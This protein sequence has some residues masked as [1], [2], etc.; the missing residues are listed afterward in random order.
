M[1]G[2]DCAR[3][4]EQGCCPDKRCLF[5]K[6]CSRLTINHGQQISLLKALR[7][8][9]GVKKVVIASGIRHDL[10]LADKK[11]GTKYLQQVIRHHV[12]GQMKIAPEHSEMHVLQK[13]GKAGREALL[14]FRDLFFDLTKRGGKKLFLTYYLI[15][16]HPGCNDDDMAQLRSFAIRDLHLLP[17]Q[18]QVF[19]PTPS[20]WSTLMYWT[21]R[22]PFSGKP[23]FVEKTSR[24]RE[25]QKDIL[26]DRRTK[27]RQTDRSRTKKRNTRR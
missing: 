10:I 14:T 3:K 13:M 22:D 24:G 2:I 5:P 20:T 23:C 21:E 1:Y 25:R 12:S 19:T 27:K 9:N 17:E 6:I 26:A 4:A 7:A 16:A 18:V 15:A 11:N 8:V